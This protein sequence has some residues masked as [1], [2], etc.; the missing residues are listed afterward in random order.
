VERAWVVTAV[1]LVSA[2]GDT[3]E[4]WLDRLQRGD[5]PAEPAA[6]DPAPAPRPIPDFDARRYL[7]Q[8]GIRHLSRTSQLACAAASRLV[9]A[10]E[11]LPG[12]E[13]GIVLGTAW[14][15]VDTIVGF[16]RRACLDGIRF[17][18]PSLFAESVAN[19]PAGHLSIFFGWSA[20]NTTVATGTT[21]GIGAVLAAIEA[22]EEDRASAMVAGGVDEL[23]GHLL[24]TLHA[25]GWSGEP[26]SGCAPGGEAACLVVLES[27]EHATRRGAPRLGRILGGF[28][29]W[30][31]PSGPH[32]VSARARSLSD[33][34]RR[35]ELEPRDLDLLVLSAS[36]RE[37]RDRPEAAVVES[38][39]GAAA[40]RTLRPKA[41][42]GEVWAAAGPLGIVAALESMRHAGTPGVALVLD[43]AESGQFA[44][45][46]VA[47]GAPR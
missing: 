10:L 46:L 45:I 39:F 18:D 32:A 29:D 23:N 27:D 6:Q 7:Q 38:V 37:E 31:E 2:V 33:L 20:L 17:V 3:P 8:K 13:V 41:I 11:G 14:A 12:E 44:S 5:P 4:A 19:V 42:L 34:L 43:C 30:I 35:S 15:S 9:P 24:R 21:S 28:N 36:G 1:G 25:E 16:E 26:G 22:L 40:P 47:G